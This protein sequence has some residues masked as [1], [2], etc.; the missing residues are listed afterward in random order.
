[1]TSYGQ[2][3]F[4]DPRR[5]LSTIIRKDK[6]ESGLKSKALLGNLWQQTSVDAKP[7]LN[8]PYLT[9]LLKFPTDNTEE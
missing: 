6:S 1:M 4:K 3:K 2:R 8:D 7:L 5:R 9:N